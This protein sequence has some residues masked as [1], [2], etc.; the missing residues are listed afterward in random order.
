MPVPP[1]GAA[2]RRSARLASER[3]FIAGATGDCQPAR[4]CKV[5]A[6]YCK[7]QEGRARSIGTLEL[8]DGGP[9]LCPYA[10]AQPIRPTT[11]ELHS[12][13]ALVQFA[14]QLRSAPRTPV[15]VV[16]LSV[17]VCV[18]LMRSGRPDSFASAELICWQTRSTS[19]LATHSLAN[20]LTRLPRKLA[21]NKCRATRQHAAGPLEA[22]RPPARTSVSLRSSSRRASSRLYK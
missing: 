11:G 10:A 21:R 19:N 4:C 20:T 7:L 6:K 3:H 18:W 15:V 2:A 1:R 16:N 9:R 13:A 5:P 14:S 12:L 8:V 17:C 22:A